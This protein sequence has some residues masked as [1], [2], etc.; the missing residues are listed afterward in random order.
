[1]S[2]L[3][4]V[5][6]PDDAFT[7]QAGQWREEPAL[8]AID[9]SLTNSLSALDWQPNLDIGFAR[10]ELSGL[11]FTPDVLD[12]LAARIAEKLQ[13]LPPRTAPETRRLRSRTLVSIRFRWPVFSFGSL[14]YRRRVRARASA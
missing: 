5:T 11:T 14:R 6:R 8:D 2:G 13:S 1:M 7:S 10:S 12:A 3:Q 9:F 4:P